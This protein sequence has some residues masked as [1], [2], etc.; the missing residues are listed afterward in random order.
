M[1]PAQP[2][3]DIEIP[4]DTPSTELLPET[5]E[6]EDADGDEDIDMGRLALIDTLFQ[7]TT[8][9]GHP[10]MYT[11]LNISWDARKG[12]MYEIRFLDDDFLVWM[13]KDQFDRMLGES[14]VICNSNI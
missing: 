5:E 7:Y 13:E 12:E 10:R 2:I 6:V 4:L 8:K 11:L 9:Q 3:D 1:L 14:S